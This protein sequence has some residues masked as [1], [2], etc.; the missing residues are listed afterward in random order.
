MDLGPIPGMVTQNRLVFLVKALEMIQVT[1]K[2][3]KMGIG[4]FSRK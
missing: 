4:C 2:T 3:A 1:P